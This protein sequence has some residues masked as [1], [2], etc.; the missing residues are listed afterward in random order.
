MEP[1]A[2]LIKHSATL[3][4]KQLSEFEEDYPKRFPKKVLRDIQEH[5]ERLRLIAIDISS[6]A[7]AL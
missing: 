2:K 4:R 3:L 6:I 5:N 1:K 7:R